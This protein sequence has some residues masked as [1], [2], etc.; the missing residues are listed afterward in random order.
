VIPFAIKGVIWYQGES[1]VNNSN[2]YRV[3][4]PIMISDWREK[5]GQGDFPFLFVQLPSFQAV[6]AQ[7]LQTTN[8][9]PGI[10]EAQFLTL[11]L[12]NTGMA[13]AI[14][15]GDP[16]NIHPRNKV[17][18]G[19]RLALVA[20]KVA[21]GQDIVASGPTFDTMK[22][23]ENKVRLSFKNTGGGL[24]FA[25]PPWVCTGKPPETPT[26]LKGFA[27]AGGNRKFEWATAQISGSD[28]IVSSDAV[29]DPKAVRYGWATTSDCNLYNAEKLP[30]VP[31]RTDDW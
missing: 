30:A 11:A 23:E 10:R 2:L 17:Y 8:G 20:R 31:F 5:W 6:Q 1:N 3:L 9:L 18:V 19:T 27:V 13:T 15:V 4:F 28:V 21:Y 16:V 25:A 7:P 14:D 26:E 29:P 12:P 24:V 22:V